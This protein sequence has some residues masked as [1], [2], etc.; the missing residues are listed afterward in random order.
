MRNKY[1]KRDFLDA[2]WFVFLIALL[3]LNLWV[4]SI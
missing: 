2:V 3:Y 1:T 4:W